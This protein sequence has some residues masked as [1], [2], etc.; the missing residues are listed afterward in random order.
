MGFVLSLST[1]LSSK[2]R[3]WYLSMSSLMRICSVSGIGADGGLLVVTEMLRPFLSFSGILAESR[4][5]FPNEEIS[6]GNGSL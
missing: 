2:N 1:L 5:M 4:C 6:L 3:P